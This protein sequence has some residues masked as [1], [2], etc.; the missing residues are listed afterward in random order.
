M[1]SIPTIAPLLLILLL[2]GVGALRTLRQNF[3][4]LF[5]TLLGATLSGF[6]GV[7]WGQDLAAQG[8]QPGMARALVEV[9][10]LLL[11]AFPIGYGS[12]VLLRGKGI[13]EGWAE[14]LSGALLGLFNGIVLSGYIVRSL[15]LANTQLSTT[16]ITNP[17]TRMLHE[18]LPLVWLLVTLVGLIVIIMQAIRK[19]LASRARSL[20]GGYQPADQSG[21]SRAEREANRRRVAERIR[22]KTER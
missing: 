8:V 9:L 14:R 17:V 5:G 7:L 20:T 3:L 19:N 6:W 11:G 13:P 2:A 21:L 16:I 4:A 15:A 10:L 18:G 1:F 22:E 12:A